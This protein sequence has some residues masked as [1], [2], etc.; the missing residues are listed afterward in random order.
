MGIRGVFILKIET[1]IQ[2][3]LQV[4][5]EIYHDLFAIPPEVPVCT[6]AIQRY[7]NEGYVT[8]A[9]HMREEGVPYA[10]LSTVYKERVLIS[11]KAKRSVIETSLNIPRVGMKSIDWPKV[12]ALND[13]TKDFAEKLISICYTRKQK[14]KER[15]ANQELFGVLGMEELSILYSLFPNMIFMAVE[16]GPKV[17]ETNLHYVKKVYIV[18]NPTFEYMLN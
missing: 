4:S 7:F 3:H 9:F 11:S 2:T 10:E 12:Y 5:V 13:E 14:E 6:D 17:P 16:L 18:T 8:L 1:D 15:R